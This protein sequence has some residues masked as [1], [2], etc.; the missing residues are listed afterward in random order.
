MIKR[1]PN[2]P[3]NILAFEATGEVTAGDY[4]TVIM[5]AVESVLRKYKKVRLLYHLGEGFTGF[6]AGAIW[7]DTKVGLK[8]LTA[9]EKV[10]LVTDVH[11]LRNT[12]KT[13]G[14]LIPGTV[15][16]FGNTEM[17][18]AREWIIY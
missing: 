12:I 6:T 2:M 16:L 7:D 14:F 9:W 15:K 13:I 5:P 3:E 11:W 18:A 17:D 10:A 4:E 8:H 1:L